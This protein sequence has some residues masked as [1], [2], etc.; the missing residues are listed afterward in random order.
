MYF[1]SDFNSYC[2]HSG[3]IFLSRSEFRPFAQK[4]SEFSLLVV[5]SKNNAHVNALLNVGYNFYANID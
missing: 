5:N 1:E 3:L 2:C 4:W